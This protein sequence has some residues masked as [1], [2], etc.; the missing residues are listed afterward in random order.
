MNIL[1]RDAWTPAHVQSVADLIVNPETN[2]GTMSELTPEQVAANMPSCPA[3]GVFDG[4]R[5]LFT[6]ALNPFQWN[7]DMSR[8]RGILHV[9]GTSELPNAWQVVKAFLES[10]PGVEVFTFTDRPALARLGARAGLEVVG[11]DGPYLIL[12]R[13]TTD[14]DQ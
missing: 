8:M 5:A 4:D 12:T 11:R 7:P 3:W 14:A 13:A 2:G 10:M 1:P 9:S 6:V